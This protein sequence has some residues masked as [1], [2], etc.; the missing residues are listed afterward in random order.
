MRPFLVDTIATILFF[1]LI[2]AFAELVIVDMKPEQVLLARSITVPVMALT[3]RPYGM[4]RSWVFKQVQASAKGS[5]L[6]ID[7]MT[8]LSFQ[9]PVYVLTLVVAGAELDEIVLA[10]TSATAIMLFIGRPF[11]IYLDAIRRWAGTA[12]A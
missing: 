11:G 6:F 8:F 3:G 2:A 12:T 7:T 5:R 1:T 10:V 9:V 4:W